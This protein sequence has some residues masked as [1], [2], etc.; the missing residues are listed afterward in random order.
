M[1]ETIGS[2]V[3][4]PVLSGTGFSTPIVYRWTVLQSRPKPGPLCRNSALWV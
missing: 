4:I 1:T 2:S 3:A